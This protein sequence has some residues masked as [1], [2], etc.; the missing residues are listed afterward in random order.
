MTEAQ[1]GADIVGAD[2]WLR[3]AGVLG[4]L[5]ILTFV[6]QMFIVPQA[7][8][9]NA[10]TG[11]ILSYYTQHRS[12]IELGAWFVGIFAFLYGAF[13]AGLWGA[14]RRTNGLW[15]ATL[16]LAA[17]IGNSATLFVGHAINVALA[18]DIASRQGADPGLVVA[19]F[20]VVSLLTMTFNTWTDGLAVL[21]FSVALLLSRVHLGWV[22]WIAWVGV[23]SGIA[24][25]V[26][27]LSIFNPAQP[28]V[29][30]DL[31][32]GLTWLIWLV[33]LSIYLIRGGTAPARH[34]SVATSAGLAATS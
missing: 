2:R 19:L 28:L 3:V 29:A 13:L 18:T 26:G 14:L 22:R 23:L 7:P 27:M 1:T 30:A 17:A 6:A 9:Y 4:V 31:V 34:A 5:F 16:G 12:G 33:G 10:R 24:F 20:K 25:L 21:A 15:L 11:V 32:A 8:D